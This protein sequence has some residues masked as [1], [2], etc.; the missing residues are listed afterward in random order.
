MFEWDKSKDKENQSK[1]GIPFADT[2]GV[3]EDPN[4][5]T[6]EDF[7][8]GEQRYVTIG[9]D[10]FGRI[11]VVVYSSRGE[12]IRIIS[13]RKAVRYEVKQYEGEI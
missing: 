12:N 4:A 9:M 10:A 5:A 1:H 2:F 13:A 3:F 7:R 11:L 8:S 6:I